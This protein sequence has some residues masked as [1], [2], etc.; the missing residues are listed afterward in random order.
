MEVVCLTQENEVKKIR[1]RS[2]LSNKLLKVII[3]HKKDEETLQMHP[4]IANSTVKR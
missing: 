1:T 4:T 2:R 3:K